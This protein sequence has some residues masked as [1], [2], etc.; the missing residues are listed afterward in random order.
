MFVEASFIFSPQLLRIYKRRYCS[1]TTYSESLEFLCSNACM[2]QI[3]DM[4]NPLNRDIIKE[5]SKC[6]VQVDFCALFP[7]LWA[8]GWVLSAVPPPN[9]TGPT[10]ER[11]I[12]IKIVTHAPREL[13]TTSSHE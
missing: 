9:A 4:N 13:V 10:A 7:I 8:I 5:C 11:I 6:D 2:F 1:Y 12:A 3:H